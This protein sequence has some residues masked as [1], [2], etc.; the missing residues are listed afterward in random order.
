MRARI[1]ATLRRLDKVETQLVDEDGSARGGV[2]VVPRI[3]SLDAWE[4]IA[5]PQLAALALAAAEDIDSREPPARY[6]D[7]LPGA[8]MP[9]VEGVHF[10]R[11]D[12]HR[13]QEARPMPPRPPTGLTR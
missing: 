8:L 6:R 7:P 4:A 13:A 3:L 2:L 11:P 5:Q 12:P 9:L 1:A 10:H